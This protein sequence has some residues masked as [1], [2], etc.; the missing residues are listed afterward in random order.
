[1]DTSDAERMRQ[2]MAAAAGSRRTVSPR[3]WVGAVV[4]PR[5]APPDHPGFVG[6][7]EGRAG[8]DGP[9]AEVAALLAAGG[10]AAGATVYVTLEPCAFAGERGR[11]C[12]EALIEAGIERAVVGIEDPDA[13]V[14]GQGL[15]QLRAAGVTVDLAARTPGL[16]R[17]AGQVADQ[18][19]PYLHHRRTGR[20]FVILK[21]AASLDGRTAAPDGTSQWITGEEAR[22]DAHRLRADSDAVLVGAG[23][24]R[25]DDPALTVRLPADELPNGF[26][27]PL[28]VVLGSAAETATAQPV[29]ELAGD[30]GQAL[31]ELGR[32]GVLQV[33]VEGGAAVAHDLHAAG[34]VDHYVIYLAPTLFGGDD[35]R[36]LFAGPGAATLADAWRGH[37]LDVRRVGDDL[38]VDLEPARPDR[39]ETGPALLSEPATSGA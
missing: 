14:A 15:A 24:V 30:L 5:D 19:R 17:V 23:T 4:V 11:S 3:P 39:N 6:A 28:R 18:L 13:R 37:V 32:R 31:D 34:L 20:P 10:A 7:T 38:R 16:E 26:V 29:V 36:G 2:A 25:S 9:H 22:R 33:L 12:A 27:Q 35:A 1:V 8:S 21:L